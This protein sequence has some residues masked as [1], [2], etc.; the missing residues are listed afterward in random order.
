VKSA[1]LLLVLV[2]ALGAAA[3]RAQVTTTSSDVTTTSSDATTT[4]PAP[5]PVIADGVSVAGVPVGG[6]TAAEAGASVHAFFARPFTF[7]FHGHTW[8]SGP[9]R[10]GA[11]I[12]LDAVVASALAAAPA[13]ALPLP[14]SVNTTT[15]RAYVARKAALYRRP[16]VNS[17][18][19]LRDLRP[20]VTRARAGYALAQFDTRILIRGLLAAHE[21]GPVEL[22]SRVVLPRLTRTNFGPVIVIRRGSHRLFLYSV[23]RYWRVFGVAVGR[24]EYPTPLGRFY[25]A[26]K[27]RNPWWYPPDSAWAAGAS[28]IPPGPGNPLGTRW[29]GLS[30]WGV[31]IHGTPDASSIGYS[32]SH[33]CIRMRISEAEWLFERVRVG[34]PVFIVSA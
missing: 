12:D 29:M 4:D 7:T 22:P 34:T 27:Q 1:L 5:P 17:R 24:P 20:Y 16:A 10:V 9:S 26:V 11:S 6:M 31:G 23:M 8:Q 21:R 32:A 15:F 28:P 2:G 33:G 19:Y 18:V 13:E 25:I 14:V 30:A 3:A